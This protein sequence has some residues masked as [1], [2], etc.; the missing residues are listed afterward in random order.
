VADAVA[1][2]K[3]FRAEITGAPDPKA[4]FREVNSWHWTP[5][6]HGHEIKS[7]VSTI[8]SPEPYISSDENSESRTTGGQEGERLLE[9]A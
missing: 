5:H 2:A 4:K 9:C 3:S 1:K 7:P 8:L 6:I